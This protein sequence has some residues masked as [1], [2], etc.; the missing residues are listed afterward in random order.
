MRNL[1][2]KEKESRFMSDFLAKQKT[3]ELVKKKEGYRYINVGNGKLFVKCDKDGN[4]VAS[5][6]PKIEKYRALMDIYYNAGIR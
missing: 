2:V 4:P 6:I 3:E 5:E 1:E